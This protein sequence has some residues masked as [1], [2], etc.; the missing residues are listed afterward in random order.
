MLNCHLH[1]P[2]YPTLPHVKVVV[3]ENLI[4][5]SFF[6]FYLLF[7]SLPTSPLLKTKLKDTL[8]SYDYHPLTPVLITICPY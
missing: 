7:T 2:S 1:R 3:I 8:G 5:M 4:L 6:R